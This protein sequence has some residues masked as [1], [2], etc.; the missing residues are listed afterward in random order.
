MVP[1]LSPGAA[2]V[3]RIP[4]RNS[5]WL[6]QSKGGELAVPRAHHLSTLRRHAQGACAAVSSRQREAPPHH[7]VRKAA[8]AHRELC[9]P[10]SRGNIAQTVRK[11]P[12]FIE[13]VK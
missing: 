5:D 10:Q 13:T 1:G 2:R 8:I 9:R 4:L 12:V 3:E 6:L 7:R 11:V